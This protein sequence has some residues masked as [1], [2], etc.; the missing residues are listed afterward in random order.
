MHLS[1][2]F[3]SNPNHMNTCPPTIVFNFTFSMLSALTF[4]HTLPAASPAPLPLFCVS[5][6]PLVL[7]VHGLHR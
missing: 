5:Q 7:C 4:H 6:Y 3:P 2:H 1:S